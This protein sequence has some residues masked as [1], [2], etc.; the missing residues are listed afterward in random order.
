MDP[1]K[2]TRRGQERI[3][4]ALLNRRGGEL[5]RW[6]PS[7]AKTQENSKKEAKHRTFKVL[8]DPHYPVVAQKQLLETL[9]SG[10]SFQANNGVVRQV[11]A[12]KLVL[13]IADRTRQKLNQ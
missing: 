12:I 7:A 4:G 11:D 2:Q 3:A 13:Q 5:P 6:K 10:K 1:A 8:C 9:E